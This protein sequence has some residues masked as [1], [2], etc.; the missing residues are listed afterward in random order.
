MI[1]RRTPV[2]VHSWLGPMYSNGNW[3]LTGSTV[4]V[5]RGVQPAAIGCAARAD[6][7]LVHGRST[8]GSYGRRQW[9]PTGAKPYWAPTALQ[10][11]KTVAAPLHTNRYSLCPTYSVIDLEA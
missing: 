9:S 1:D 6:G 8:G 11:A 10:S 4:C 3:E 2:L 5:K 7:G